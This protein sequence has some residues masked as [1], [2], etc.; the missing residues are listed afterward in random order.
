MSLQ[1]F[2]QFCFFGFIFVSSYFAFV[3]TAAAQTV[4]SFST[5]WKTD[6]V[7]T[8]ANNQITIPTTGPGYNYN[9]YWEQVG[10][11]AVNG[12]STGHVGN[13]TVTFP[14]PGTYRVDITGSFPRIY[15]NNGGDR[16]KILTVEQWGN[17]AWTSMERSFMGATNLT[18]PASDAPNLSGVTSLSR[19]FSLATSFNSAINHWNV[20]T[21]TNFEAFL[22]GAT[23]F[24][25]PLNS[26]DVSNA[27]TMFDMFY[28]ASAFNQPLNSWDVRQVQYMNGMFLE[29]TAFNQPLN[30]WDVGNVLEMSSMFQGATAF[31]QPL[32]QWDISQVTNL[33][34]MFYQASAFNQP[35]NSW[36]V[37]SVFNMDSMFW[38]ASAFNQPLDQWDL[39]SIT[40]PTWF[41]FTD[42]AINVVN[43]SKTLWGWATKA[44]IPSNLILDRIGSSITATSYCDTAQTYRDTLTSTYGWTMD[45]AGTTTCYLL[46]YATSTGGTV[47]G[48]TTQFV[49]PAGN[50]QA[51]TAVPNSGYRFLQ[52]SDN[53]VVNPRQDTGVGSSV[54]IT[55]LFES[56]P[57]TSS[58]SVSTGSRSG[59]TATK[60]LPPF[61]AYLLVQ[62]PHLFTR[63]SFLVPTYTPEQRLVM[64]QEIINLLQQLINMKQSESIKQ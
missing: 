43:Y 16:R 40:N 39:R 59:G 20:G 32:D 46:T 35:L 61:A 26:W 4:G 42:T 44:V 52:W 41:I 51:V 56:I 53:S 23:A 29:A 14:A 19:M 58:E 50:G 47:S 5:T 12:S 2:V 15:F 45:D 48:D 64:M 9:I 11:P 13:V 3:D 17:N 6:N 7:G 28:Q 25:Q 34:Y 57:V 38:E 49:L 27:T 22:S 60:V 55:A 18:V 31:N 1:K 54:A 21:I 62:H 36:D 10:S 8:S 30:S 63:S 37:S 24:N 33:D